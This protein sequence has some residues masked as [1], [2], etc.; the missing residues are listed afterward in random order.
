MAVIPLGTVNACVLTFNDVTKVFTCDARTSLRR[1]LR[2]IYFNPSTGVEV[3]RLDI[4]FGVQRTVTIATATFTRDLTISRI[5]P[6]GQ[7][8]HPVIDPAFSL[9]EV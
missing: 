3:A 9:S 8:F 2:L 7:S 5:G 1:A 4:P 6:D